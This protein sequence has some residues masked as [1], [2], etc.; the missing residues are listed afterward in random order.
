MESTPT[1]SVIIPTYNRAELVPHAIESVL[2]QTFRD[3]ELLV[4]DDGSTDDTRE[5]VEAIEDPRVRYLYQENGGVSAA[6]NYGAREANGE[7]LIFLDSDDTAYPDWLETMI[8]VVQQEGVSLAC[9]GC[10]MATSRGTEGRR[11]PQRLGT[12]HRGMEG[13]FLAGTFIVESRLFHEV[14]GYDP[15]MQAS[16]NW[17]LGIRLTDWLRNAG[18]DTHC[19][20]RALITVTDQGPGRGGLNYFNKYEST[21]HLYRKHQALFQQH[22]HLSAQLLAQAGVFAFR[23]GMKQKS[24]R[25]FLRAAVK[26]I[27]NGKHWLRI[28]VATIPPVGEWV[29]R[30]AVSEIE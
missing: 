24:T 21:L 2:A 30:D 6:R 18:Q 9:C 5:A 7:Y 23:A 20:H 1:V 22:R 14:G 25:L 4:V 15:N 17:E 11:M 16:E 3:F 10:E 19:I 29:W 12:L 26:D 28:L 27:L 8:S 13:V